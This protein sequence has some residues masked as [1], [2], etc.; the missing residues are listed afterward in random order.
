MRRLSCDDLKVVQEYLNGFC[1]ADGRL[2]FFRIK[3]QNEVRLWES[4]GRKIKTLEK[5]TAEPE[6]AMRFCRKSFY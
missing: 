1:I 5:A 3:R 4:L 6:G 2:W